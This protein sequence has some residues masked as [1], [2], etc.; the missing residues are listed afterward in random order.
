[1]NLSESCSASLHQLKK[2]I[3]SIFLQQPNVY[4]MLDES[5]RLM[6]HSDISLIR[7]KVEVHRDS[8]SLQYVYFHP[9]RGFTN[10]AHL[11]HWCV[12]FLAYMIEPRHFLT[13]QGINES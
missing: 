13:L 9:S 4:T 5:Q 2:C 10:A 12:L 7:L 3:Y 11:V 1:M 8:L 6:N